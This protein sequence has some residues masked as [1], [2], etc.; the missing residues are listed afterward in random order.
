[1]KRRVLWGALAL[2]LV[3]GAALVTSCSPLGEGTTSASAARHGGSLERGFRTQSSVK[4]HSSGAR[5]NQRVLAESTRGN[6][7]VVIDIADQR[8][9]LLVNG[10]VAV[11]T[12]VST[13]RPGKW[14]P[15]GSFSISERVR[16]GK[17]STIYGVGMPYWMRLSGS[18]IGVHAGHLPGYPASAGCIRLP[19]N[20][21]QVIYDNTTYGTRVNV[22]SS[23]DGA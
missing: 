3:L 11:D 14:T 21:A 16:S 6:T 19:T 1:M 12:P 5:V 20:A 23:W 18:V 15:R 7:R 17:V 9:Y 22:Y 13:A 8:G 2:P 4:R 10:K